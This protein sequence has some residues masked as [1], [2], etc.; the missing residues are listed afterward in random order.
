MNDVVLTWERPTI[1]KSLPPDLIQ[2]PTSVLPGSGMWSA[3]RTAQVYHF[4]RATYIAIRAIAESMAENKAKVGFKQ[5]DG[6]IIDAEVGHPLQRLCDN[7]NIP[8]VQWQFDYLTWVYVELTGVAYWLLDDFVGGRPQSK[9]VI[10]SHW[11]WPKYQGGQKIGYNVYP[12]FGNVRF[13]SVD[14]IVEIG[15]PNPINPLDW[16]SPLFACDNWIDT[17]ESLDYSRHADFLACVLPSVLIELTQPHPGATMSEDDLTRMQAKLMGRF[18]GPTK[19]GRPIV[20]PPGAKLH[21]YDKQREMHYNESF[22]QMLDA[23]LAVHRVPRML[24]GISKEIN[25]ANGLATQQIYARYTIQPKLEL[26]SQVQT[27]KVANR[28]YGD[29]CCIYYPS[30][31]PI[32][33]DQRNKD[34]DLLAKNAAITKNELRKN[35]PL[36]LEPIE[37]GDELIELP[38]TGA[39]EPDADDS[40]TK[41]ND[42]KSERLELLR[43][44]TH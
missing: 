9:W 34:L 26:S 8:D 38:T 6:T 39:S 21:L 23:V 20:M 1:E 11:V 27:E 17:A 28:F 37:G 44:G 24:A 2:W 42:G 16:M 25:K 32:D 29:D 5:T 33:P 22:E 15:Y 18:A 3:N 43:N 14:E 31:V 7:P 36:K 13:Y 41:P 19:V 35:S 10:P 4:K 12:N 30:P 40:D